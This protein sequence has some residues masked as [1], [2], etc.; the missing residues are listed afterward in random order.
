MTFDGCTFD[1]NK[2]GTVGVGGNGGAVRVVFGTVNIT[3]GTIRENT[4]VGVGGGVS[5]GSA[6]GGTVNANGVAFI[7]NTA[8]FPTAHYGLTLAGV[9]NHTNCTYQ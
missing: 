4:A 5:V 3:G 1:G 9:Y 2:A 7:G 6:A 8:T